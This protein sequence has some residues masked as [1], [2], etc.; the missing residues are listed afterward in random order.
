MEG[1]G[2]DNAK[3]SSAE[4]KL[5]RGLEVDNKPGRVIQAKLIPIT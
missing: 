3:V 5:P 4:V 2:W 1:T